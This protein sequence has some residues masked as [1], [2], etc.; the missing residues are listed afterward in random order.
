[1]IAL[2]ICCPL[3]DGRK[4]NVCDLGMRFGR[5]NK[6]DIDELDKKKR[7]NWHFA[8]ND[9]INFY[10]NLCNCCGDSFFIIGIF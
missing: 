10:F 8:N 6:N 4:L 1:M 2:I 3:H 7:T 5:I 9:R